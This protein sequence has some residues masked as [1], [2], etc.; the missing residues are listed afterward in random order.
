MKNTFECTDLDDGSVMVVWTATPFGQ[1]KNPT[2]VVYRQHE[3]KSWELC[4]MDENI[5][6]PKS[7]AWYWIPTDKVPHVVKHARLKHVSA[8]R[9]GNGSKR[10]RKLEEYTVK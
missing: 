6:D 2:V 4:R 10:V 5:Q 8:I 9:K 7:D 3:D 1:P